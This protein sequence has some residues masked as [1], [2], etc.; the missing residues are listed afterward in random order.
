MGGM[1]IDCSH[2]EDDDEV[3]DEEAGLSAEHDSSI[4]IS[5]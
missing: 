2:G 1:Q 3:E 5:T 4:T